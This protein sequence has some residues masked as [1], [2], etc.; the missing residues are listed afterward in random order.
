MVANEVKRLRAR[1]PICVAP[2]GSHTRFTALEH[3]ATTKTRARVDH[4]TRFSVR[5]RTNHYNHDAEPYPNPSSA[6]TH[7]VQLAR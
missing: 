6:A 2:S 5:T 7:R 3:A 1:K 4:G